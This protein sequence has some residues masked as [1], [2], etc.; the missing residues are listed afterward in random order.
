MF[1]C[2]FVS[3]FKKKR[4]KNPREFLVI[5]NLVGITTTSTE[6][7]NKCLT[8]FNKIMVSGEDRDRKSVV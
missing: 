7:L 8:I 6:L 1:V 2:S 4:C 3:S 5:M